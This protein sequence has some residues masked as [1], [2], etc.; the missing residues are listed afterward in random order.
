MLASLAVVPDVVVAPVV[1]TGVVVITV[2]V[3]EIN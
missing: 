2:P 3:K 1:V